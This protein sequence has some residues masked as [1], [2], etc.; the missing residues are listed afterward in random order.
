M[1][2][3]PKSEIG[4][5]YLSYVENRARIWA[6]KYIDGRE[7]DY[8][9]DAVLKRFHFCNVW[10][11]LDRYSRWEIGQIRGRPLAKQL[12][13][14][15]IGRMSMIPSTAKL[16]LSGATRSDMDQYVAKRRSAGLPWYNGAIQVSAYGGNDFIDEF[17][18]HRDTYIENRA[19]VIKAAKSA[20]D[21]Q[22]FADHIST[23]VYKVGGFR[24]YEIATSLTYSEH[25]PRLRED[26][27]FILGPGAVEGLNFLTG[28]TK[29]DRAVFESLHAIVYHALLRRRAFRW[30][31]I[32]W[33]G[34]VHHKEVNKFTLRT[35]E[36]SLC[37]FR[38]YWN[39][40]SGRTKARRTYKILGD[41][42]V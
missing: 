26:Q 28:Q 37:E 7:P 24:A 21:A 1:S 13:T 3:D 33:Q 14:I 17:L 29:A 27:L 30:V 18:R 42:N 4:L 9:G 36:D 19:A 10:R 40:A 11:E 8:R 2:F 6:E 23:L 41:I 12:D 20:G 38:K 5:A 22:D 32:N 35:L 31:P 16:L 15:V 25:L 39:I 34:S